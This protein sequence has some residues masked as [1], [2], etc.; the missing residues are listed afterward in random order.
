MNAGTHLPP[1]GRNQDT[2]QIGAFCR[3]EI[4]WLVVGVYAAKRHQKQTCLN[5]KGTGNFEI[6]ISLFKWDFS[7]LTI[8]SVFPLQL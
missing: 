6:K 5:I 8:A 1:G 3:I 7:V 4:G 2:I